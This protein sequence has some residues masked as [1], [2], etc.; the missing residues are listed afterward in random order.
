MGNVSMVI[1]GNVRGLDPLAG[2]DVWVRNLTGYT[3]TYITKYDPLGYFKLA[4]ITTN[5]EGNGSFHFN[6]RTD[7]LPDRVYQIQVAINPYNN[8]GITV[9][10]TQWP[11]MTVT[12]KAQ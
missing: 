5:A 1:Q 8:P 12:V 10:A 3:G 2:Y 6:L 9:I 7:E 11:G 4:T